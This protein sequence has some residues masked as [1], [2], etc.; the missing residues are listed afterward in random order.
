MRLAVHER[1]RF[2]V[3]CD[4]FALLQDFCL[5]DFSNPIVSVDINLFCKKGREKLKACTWKG[6]EIDMKVTHGVNT[7]KNIPYYLESP[8]I[9]LVLLSIPAFI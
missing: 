9:N 8:S 1:K 4:I 7:L 2:D 6:W 5:I 3:R